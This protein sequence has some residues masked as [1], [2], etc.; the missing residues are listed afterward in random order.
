MLLDF[1][2][3]SV[4]GWEVA[5]RSKGNH[6]LDEIKYGNMTTCT[7]HKRPQKNYVIYSFPAMCH[8]LLVKFVKVVQINKYCTKRPKKSSNLVK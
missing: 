3:P 8:N 6:F 1:I 7:P 5:G 2:L 4:D